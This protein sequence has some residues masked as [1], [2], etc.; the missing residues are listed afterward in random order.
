MMYGLVVLYANLVRATIHIPTGIYAI[1]ITKNTIWT[2]DES[3]SSADEGVDVNSC[4][5]TMKQITAVNIIRPTT[6]Y[7]RI[8]VSFLHLFG[9]EI[10]N[11]LTR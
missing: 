11:N 8:L 3:L 9:Y 7:V 2:S 6:M 4:E 5:V 1:L 10:Y